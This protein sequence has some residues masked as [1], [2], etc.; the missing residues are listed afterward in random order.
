MAEELKK[1]LRTRSGHR[2]VVKNAFAKHKE[3]LPPAG[4]SVPN[5]I[6]PRLIS[7]K[8]TLISFHFIFLFSFFIFY[9]R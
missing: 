4:A 2:L 9:P 8:N 1:N 6:K 5:E 7:F 3:F